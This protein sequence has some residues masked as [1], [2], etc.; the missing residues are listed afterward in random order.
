MEIVLSFLIGYSFGSLP[1]AY[2]IIKKRTG[3][4]ITE[5][6]SGNVG[7]HNSYD[8]S[9]SKLIGL[10]VLLIDLLKGLLSI[11]LVRFLFGENFLN[12][13]LALCAAVLSHCFSPWIKFKGGRG[14][15]TSLGGVLIISIPILLIWIVIWIFTFIL[16]KDIH[17]ANF[18]ASIL[19]V[20]LSFFFSEILIKYTNPIPGS[21]LQFII[22]V[23]V[24]FLI[25]ILKH[26]QPIKEYLLL[27]Q[28]KKLKEQT[29][30]S[31]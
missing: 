12:E 15:A 27:L 21:E 9:K 2:I 1:T 28:N 5:N 20:I 23:S 10:L 16:R 3:L 4:D 19:T 31:I 30:E 13:M 25:I 14:L 26:I 11:L 18:L 17:F 6:G 29:D 8:I 24:L 22:F 7:A